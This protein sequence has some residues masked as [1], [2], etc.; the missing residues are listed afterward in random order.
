MSLL[1]TQREEN[2]EGS[3]LKYLHTNLV[4]GEGLPVDLDEAVG[5]ETDSLAF[6]LQARVLQ[7]LP[8][9]EFRSTDAARN[10]GEDARRLVTVEIFVRKAM[11]F[12]EESAGGLGGN[13]RKAVQLRDIVDDYLS[14]GNRIPIYQLHEGGDPTVQVGTLQ[15]MSVT[16]Q[17]LPDVKGQGTER[18]LSH[19]NYTATLRFDRQISRA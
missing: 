4:E 14:D 18:Q 17:Q 12:V 7:A 16:E 2:V 8:I 10:R 9:Q 6:W 5:L 3:I 19:R 1:D 13:T 11:I 15:V